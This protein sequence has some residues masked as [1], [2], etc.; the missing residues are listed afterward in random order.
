MFYGATLASLK[1]QCARAQSKPLGGEPN[2]HPS[3]ALDAPKTLNN[4]LHDE[5]PGTLG[6]IIGAVAV[7]AYTPIAETSA[8]ITAESEIAC[9]ISVNI[10]S[11]AFER[12]TRKAVSGISF[13]RIR[14]SAGR[15]TPSQRGENS[16]A[17]L[18]ATNAL[19]DL[20]NAG[21]RDKY[22]CGYMVGAVGLVILARRTPRCVESA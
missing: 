19:G 18:S 2:C 11:L 21:K 13:T 16:G 14:L 20:G 22:V 6:V 5:I 9:K 8:T 7:D 17:K 3:C 4:S 10:A 1:E 12:S 15:S